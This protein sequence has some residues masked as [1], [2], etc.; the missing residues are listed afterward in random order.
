[1][2]IW[3]GRKDN[4][5]DR[6]IGAK[7]RRT[8]RVEKVGFCGRVR[9]LTS[10]L[11]LSSGSVGRRTTEHITPH[12]SWTFHPS[13]S[14]TS[15]RSGSYS[16][17]NAAECARASLFQ[18]SGNERK[19]TLSLSLSTSFDGIKNLSAETER[20]SCGRVEEERVLKVMVKHRALLEMEAETR[21]S[22]Q[23]TRIFPMKIRID[24]ESRVEFSEGLIEK[25][26]LG[27]VSRQRTAFSILKFA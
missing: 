17:G 3:V 12:P 11:A 10:V 7:D 4:P 6:R 23:S 9:L 2:K 24:W 19:T 5:G 1:M 26:R 14:P 25:T 13:R 21:C 16:R 18:L 27:R 15:R 20:R 8:K 22:V